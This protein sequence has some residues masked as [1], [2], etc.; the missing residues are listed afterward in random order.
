[1]QKTKPRLDG[2]RILLIVAVMGRVRHSRN[3]SFLPRLLATACAALIFGLGLFAA[4]PALH[5][6]LHHDAGATGG[7][8]CAVVLFAGGVSV[9]V[10]A[11]AVPPPALEWKTQVHFVSPDI[12]LESPRY[13][14]RPGRGPPVLS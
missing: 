8:G 5:G 12:C 11:I 7:D 13:R 4:S 1:M 6:E 14:L 9:P 10:V 2:G 3:V